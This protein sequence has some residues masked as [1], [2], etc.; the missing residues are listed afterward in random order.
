MPR[1]TYA[2]YVGSNNTHGQKDARR[3]VTE[4][5]SERTLCLHQ[6]FDAYK[7]GINIY[8]KYSEVTVLYAIY[9]NQACIF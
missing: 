7:Y 5:K 1:P 6:I 2:Q 8:K 9:F 3:L 4:L